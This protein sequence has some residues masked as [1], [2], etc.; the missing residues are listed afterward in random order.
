MSKTNKFSFGDNVRVFPSKETDAL[1]LAGK[2]GQVYGET[3]PSVTE[4]EVIGKTDD[5]Y[6]I[7]VSI[8]E[9]GGEYWF[10]P[11]LLELI[12]HAEGTEIRIGNHRAVRRADGSWEE[13]TVSPRKQ[14]WQFW[15]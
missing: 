1:G 8:E 6:A 7:N 14:W 11:Y 2:T 9:V 5:D 4:V 10:A 15:K 3:T 12:D 13:S